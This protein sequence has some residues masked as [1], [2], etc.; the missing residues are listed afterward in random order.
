MSKSTIGRVDLAKAIAEKTGVTKAVASATLEAFI[1]IVKDSLDNGVG[2]SI[3]GF[4]GFGVKSTPD[5]NCYNI[6][7]GES[8]LLEAHD[9]PT[10]KFAKDFKRSIAK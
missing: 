2:V 4:G 8:Y 1:S 10:F 9:R 6:K 5:R 7:T 3:N